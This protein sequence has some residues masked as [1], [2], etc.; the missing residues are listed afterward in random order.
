MKRRLDDKVETK[1]CL[2]RNPNIDDEQFYLKTMKKIPESKMC[3]DKK[4]YGV[5]IL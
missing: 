4:G 5:K 2:Y 3:K 1:E